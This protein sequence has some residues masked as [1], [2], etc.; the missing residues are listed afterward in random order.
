MKKSE[1][2]TARKKGEADFWERKT[3]AAHDAA[4]DAHTAFL[5]AE[6]FTEAADA[7]F[8]ECD[9]NNQLYGE[10]GLCLALSKKSQNGKVVTLRALRSWFD[11]DSCTHLQ[12]A[13]Q[14]AYL[15]I[16]AQ[17]ETDPRYR[18][19]GGMPA[20][21]IFLLKQPRLGGYT[22]RTEQKSETAVNITYGPATDQSDFA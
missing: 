21:A 5:T 18:E 9:A 4:K 2:K 11:G 14:A 6:A 15:R 3:D 22:D 20:K 8:D 19:K 13:V 12:G 10:A 1:K 17:I 16:Q 7:Y